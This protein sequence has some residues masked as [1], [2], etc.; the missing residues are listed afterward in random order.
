MKKGFLGILLGVVYLT[1]SS[2]SCNK[3]DHHTNPCDGAMCTA[4]FVMINTKVTDATGKTILLDEAYTRRKSNN[5]VY[6]PDQT[7]ATYDSSY[8]VLDDGYLQKMQNQSDTFYFIGIK[9]GVEVVNEPF[10]I[11]ADCCHVNKQSGKT[12]IVTK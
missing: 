11:S 5:E 4:M 1:T 3:H 10:V 6:R 2:S 9:N 12:N 7:M 8:I